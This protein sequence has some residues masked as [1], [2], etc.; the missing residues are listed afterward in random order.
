MR[1]GSVNAPR[2][3]DH[4]LLTRVYLRHLAVAAAVAAAA[5]VELCVEALAFCALDLFRQFPDSFFCGGIGTVWRWYLYQV[6]LFWVRKQNASGLQALF[7]NLDFGSR[8]RAV[9]L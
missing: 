9:G 2:P 6:V 1:W 3:S 4:L 5:V 8:I 7:F